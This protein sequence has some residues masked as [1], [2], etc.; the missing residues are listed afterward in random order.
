MSLSL[1]VIVGLV[2]GVSI[3]T[4]RRMFLHRT[5]P[6]LLFAV[7]V[8]ATVLPLG[9]GWLALNPPA[10]VQT[11]EVQGPDGKVELDAAPGQALMATGAIAIL[12]P[13]LAADPASRDTSWTLLVEGEGWKQRMEGTIKRKKE[14]T[15]VK[16]EIP[17][18]QDAVRGQKQ[19]TFGWSREERQ[20]RFRFDGD[21]H[22][23]ATLVKWN[24]KAA[25]GLTLEVI[26]WPIPRIALW[27]AA[28]VLSLLGI[29]CDLR[30]G[31]DRLASDV[32]FLVFAAL[33]IDSG[34]TPLDNI[35]DVIF[36]MCAGMVVGGLSVGGVAWVAEFTLKRKPPAP[37]PPSGKQKK[38][39]EEPKKIVAMND[40]G[41][42]G[43]RR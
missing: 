1:L 26:P 31:T 19:N 43:R 41:P 38:K 30:Y 3:T 25:T 35:L 23:S 27:A 18:D 16:V 5:T 40:E 10:A 24:G 7:L 17:T 29:V 28:I 15:E 14:E 20:E 22:V 12:D 33:F 42:Q 2:L 11:V 6:W 21:G 34:V 37:P 9:M 39:Q 32:G 8:P 13:K 36:Q 4:S